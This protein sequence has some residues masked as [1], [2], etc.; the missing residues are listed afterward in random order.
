MADTATTLAS[1]L[2]DAW[3]SP[4][5][6]KQFEDAAGPL[7]RMEKF[8]GTMIGAQ[9]QVPIYKY[10]AGGFTS[11]GAAGGSFNTY[12]NVGVDQAI[13]TLVTLGMPVSIELSAINQAGTDNAQSVISG[14]ML[15]IQAGQ[16]ELGKQAVR[17]L[18]TNGDSIVAQCDTSG[19]STTVPLIASPSG[20][21]YGYD[22]LVRRWLHVGS[23]VDIG[24]T[25]DTDSLVTAT[26]VTA[27]ADSAS[28]PTITVGTS[29]TTANGTHFVYIANPN[30][31]TAANP[32]TNGLRNLVATTGAVGGI[33]PS[34]AGQEFWKAAQRDTS[35]TVLSLDLLL[36]LQRNV[37]QQSGQYYTDVWTSYKQQANLYSLLQNQVRYTGDLAI[38]AGAV[39]QVTWNNNKISAYPDILDSDLY[40]LTLSDF[41]RVHGSIDSPTWLSD[42]FA[43]GGGQKFQWAQGAT[44]GVDA[45][46]YPYQIGLQRRNT[47]AA[48]TAL[49]A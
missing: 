10:N 14:K 40:V 16:S 2:K 39:D 44:N 45:V 26:T 1:V 23:I 46:V 15:E 22:A 25:A 37:L 11:F 48:A 6:A 33:N 42:V 34:T 30:S 29:I 43:G 18:V 13:Y 8:E 20:S 19:G 5:L 32:E 36:S 49:T 27:L 24:T 28:A 3:T 47:S 12:N 38:G 9:A 17:Q 7:K 41:V 31:T 21:A 4:R 35:T